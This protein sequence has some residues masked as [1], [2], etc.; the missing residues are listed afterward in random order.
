MSSRDSYKLEEF[1]ISY[2]K[3]RGKRFRI[4]GTGGPK[5]ATRFLKAGIKAR[6]D[7]TQ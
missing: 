6:K 7:R 4:A 1:S 2:N 3:Q 5:N